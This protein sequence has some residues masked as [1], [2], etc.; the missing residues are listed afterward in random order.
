LR[1]LIIDDE[2]PARAK[3]RRLLE[4]AADVEIAGDAAT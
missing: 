2:A 3:V 1:A 4:A